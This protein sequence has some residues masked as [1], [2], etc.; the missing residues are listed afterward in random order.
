MAG[1]DRVLALLA[2]GDARQA[3][4]EVIREHG[5]AVLRYLRALL[6]DEGLA[7]DA[8]S[9]F[10]EW[11]WQAMENYRGASAI[12]TW[13]FGIALN[14]ARRVRDEAWQKHRERLE[15]SEASKLAKEVR[16]SSLV[17]RE[18]RADRLQELRQELKPDEQNLL[19]LRLDQQLSWEEIAAILTEA[20]EPIGAAAL[21]KRFERLKV[22]IAEMARERGLLHRP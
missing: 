21:R 15:T 5:P 18:R 20:G 19:V 11:A 3:A 13:A 12:R 22:C 7:G 4:T 14:A 6:R 8:F 16:T 9:L 17:E 1:D 10:A 2:A